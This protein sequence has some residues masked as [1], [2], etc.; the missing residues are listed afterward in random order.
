MHR[1]RHGLKTYLL[2][3]S[4]PRSFT[5][6]S[7]TAFTDFCLHRFVWANRFLFLVFLI[8]LFLCRP[9]VSF[10]AHVNISY[11][12]VSSIVCVMRA[13]WSR[14]WTDS[15]VECDVSGSTDETW[16]RCPLRR[17]CCRVSRG[18]HHVRRWSALTLAVHSWPLG[19]ATSCSLDWRFLRS[20][21]PAAHLP[22][23]IASTRTRF[24]NTRIQLIESYNFTYHDSI[25]RTTRFSFLRPPVLVGVVYSPPCVCLLIPLIASIAKCIM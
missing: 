3:K 1:H 15:V 23:A 6:S 24:A 25:C 16:L 7:R 19:R 5:S 11:H 14:K 21:S 18:G 8:F 17:W 20:L 4:Y 22:S 12:I 9:F 10:W 13:W 2:H